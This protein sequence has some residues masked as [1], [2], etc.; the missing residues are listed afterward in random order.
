MGVVLE[1]QHDENDV[2]ETINDLKVVFEKQ[3]SFYIE[4]AILDFK[5]DIF[6]REGFFIDSGNRC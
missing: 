6:G 1:E 3:L 4:T 5:K 2:V